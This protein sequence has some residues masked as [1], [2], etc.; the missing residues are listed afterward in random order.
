[1]NVFDY[2]EN[3]S[4]RIA[5][6]IGV[7]DS[8]DDIELYEYSIFM[9]LSH[10][11]TSGMGLIL[12]I[13]FGYLIPYLII[14][15]VF[16]LLRHGAGGYHCETFRDCFITTNS[17]CLISGISSILFQDYATILWYV[18][19]FGGIF[20]M[21]ICPKPTINT[22]SRGYKEDIRFRKKYRNSL[23]ILAAISYFMLYNKY[24]LISSSISFG[25]L[26]VTFIVSDFGEYLLNKIWNVN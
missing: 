11:F 7:N 22:P 8:E 3:T 24:I 26:A 2:I 12:S 6:K 18:S 13:G 15:I 10:I 4:H 17:I 25:I 5:C 1:M 14:N 23:L 21:P 16:M 9:I 20:I 19:L